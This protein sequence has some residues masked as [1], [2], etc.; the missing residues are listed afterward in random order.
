MLQRA[1]NLGQTAAVGSDR[2]IN[3]MLENGID[4]FIL[5]WKKDDQHIRPYT[6][7]LEVLQLVKHF[8]KRTNEA[9]FVPKFSRKETCWFDK[10][11]FG[12]FTAYIADTPLNRD[13]LI[14]GIYSAPYHVAGLI[15]KDGTVKAEDIQNELQAAAAKFG[16]TAPI[17]GR[18]QGVYGDSLPDAEA[19]AKANIPA[20]PKEKKAP[21]KAGPQDF[22]Q[23]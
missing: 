2:A 13:L 18:F 22:T 9:R 7:G 10:D 21:V 5:R 4:V 15:K 19:V 8:N 3:A 6:L 23:V 11:E 12:I 17:K 20:P 16:I 1:I 14:G